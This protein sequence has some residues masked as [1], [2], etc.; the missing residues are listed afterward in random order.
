MTRSTSA[1]LLGR[2]RDF[3]D[4]PAWRDFEA[5]YRPRLLA[6]GKRAGLQDCDAEDLAQKV[7]VKVA[8]RIRAFDYDPERSFSGWLRTVW[9][10]AWID[11]L[12]E[13]SPGDRGTG[14]SAVLETLREVPGPVDDLDELFEREVLAE[15]M[16]RVRPRVSPR[17]WDI[18]AELVLEEK[19][20]TEVATRF[21][22]TLAA[23]GMAKLR[24]QRKVG[25][26]IARLEKGGGTREEG[27]GERG[28]PS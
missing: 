21:G 27:G 4:A 7:M 23:V 6:W 1:T 17:D 22:M 19:K 2:L 26:E 20:G 28:R 14:D 5:R 24:V 8:A 11:T 25:E 18:F 16:A 9:H 3:D 10:N 12:K 13:A 15:A